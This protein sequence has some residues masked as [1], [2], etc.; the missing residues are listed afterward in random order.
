MALHSA[1]AIGGTPG[2]PPTV[3]DPRSCQCGEVL[4]DVIGPHGCEV[5]GTACKGRTAPGPLKGLGSPA[6][7]ESRR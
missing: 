7:G 4:K 5:F 6:G 2:S 1:G 3:A